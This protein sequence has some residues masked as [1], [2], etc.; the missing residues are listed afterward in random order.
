MKVTDVGKNGIQ[1][2]LAGDA[3]VWLHSHLGLYCWSCS[4]RTC[5][6][7][8]AAGAYERGEAQPGS[9]VRPLMKKEE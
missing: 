3:V 7:V 6:H 8:Q 5:E 9:D 2:W 4:S 1:E